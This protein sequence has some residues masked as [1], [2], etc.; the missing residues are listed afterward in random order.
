MKR[1]AVVL[2]TITVIC[3]VLYAQQ[4]DKDLHDKGL[5]RG[6]PIHNGFWQASQFLEFDKDSQS[7]YATGLLDGMYLSPAF[8]AP[9]SN[10]VL[11]EIETCVEGMKSTQVAAIIEKY[12]KD[13]PE[14]WNW[15]LKNAG[16][17]AMLD[18]CRNR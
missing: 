10:K 5:H 17:N 9:A 11:L 18:A 7:V 16:Y 15:D 3:S 13:H 4:S 2:F 1:S 14:K 12:V 8:G 6:D